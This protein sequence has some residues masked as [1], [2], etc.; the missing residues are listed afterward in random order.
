MYIDRHKALIGVEVVQNGDFSTVAF[1]AREILHRAT[2]LSARY[3]VVIQNQPHGAEEPD[4]RNLFEI[5]KIAKS[6]EGI[7]VG[8]VDYVLVSPD[9]CFS[10]NEMSRVDDDRRIKL[11]FE[12]H[13]PITADQEQ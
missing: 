10:F 13:H 5:F 11:D 4:F 8:L 9:M 2:E 7:G 3:I 12:Y 6:G 1:F